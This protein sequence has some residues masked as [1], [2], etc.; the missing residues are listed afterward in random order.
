MLRI[1]SQVILRVTV[2]EPSEAASLCS[3]LTSLA[4][5]I[6]PWEADLCGY[7]NGGPCSVAS[8]PFCLSEPQ[9]MRGQ[10]EREASG[11]GHHLP[12]PLGQGMPVAVL[13]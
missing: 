9:E 6:W 10:E 5:L 11:C 1:L 13:P 4:T 2:P 3:P 7:I 12:C 8:S